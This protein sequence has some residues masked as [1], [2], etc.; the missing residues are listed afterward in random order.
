MLNNLFTMSIEFMNNSMLSTSNESLNHVS[1]SRV[2]IATSTSDK[3]I[4]QAL[5][6]VI[7]SQVYLYI[8]I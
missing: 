7:N 3:A 6:S 1:S 4:M 2:L 8:Y 5:A